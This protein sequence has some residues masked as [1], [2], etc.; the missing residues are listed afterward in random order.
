MMSIFR[1]NENREHSLA[2]NHTIGLA[3]PSRGANQIEIWRG[4]MDADAAT[5]PHAHDSEDVVLL[6]SGRRRATLDEKE[7]PYRAGD[8]MILPAHKVHQIF[9]DSR[10]EFVNATRIGGIVTLRDGEVLDL[11]WRE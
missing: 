3:T 4:H 8:T 2:G 11:P 7:I 6:L 9:A 5:P 1:D 10:T